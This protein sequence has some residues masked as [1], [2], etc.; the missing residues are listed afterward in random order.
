MWLSR[1]HFDLIKE[2]A[3]EFRAWHDLRVSDL[4]TV[5]AR[6]ERKIDQLEEEKRSLQNQLFL[7]RDRDNSPPPPLPDPTPQDWDSIRRS[8]TAELNEPEKQ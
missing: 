4:Q 1:A 8:Q 2:R 6:Q 3:A 7:K 5:I